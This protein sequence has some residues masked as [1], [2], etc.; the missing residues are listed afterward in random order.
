MREKL[1]IADL[2]KEKLF[3]ANKIIKIASENIAASQFIEYQLLKNEQLARFI[4]L[5][6]NPLNEEQP[7]RKTVEIRRDP[8][9]EVIEEFFLKLI[10][11]DFINKGEVLGAELKEA[12]V[13]IWVEHLENTLGY[14]TN[15]T[16]DKVTKGGLKGLMFF[17]AK[18][19][20]DIVPR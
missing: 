19:S 15:P 2:I 7:I 10:D 4:T 16:L 9:D 17:I 3:G 12:V 20:P 5:Y 11:G 1:T 6:P 14:G 18:E 8:E 13:P